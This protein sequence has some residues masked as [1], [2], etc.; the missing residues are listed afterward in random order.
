MQRFHVHLHVRDLESSVAFYRRVFGSEPDVLKSDYAKWLRDDPALNFALS[1]T[2]AGFGISHL[3][4]QL[5][6]DEALGEIRSR[7]AAG[8]LQSLDQKDAACCYA[9]SDKAWVEDPDGV[10]WEAFR[11]HGAIDDYGNDL[12]DRPQR[13]D[14]PAQTNCC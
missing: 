7:I 12:L 4:L 8:G 14:Q 13:T 10:R 11:T 6:S 5:D 2:E 3:G 9:R 1:Q